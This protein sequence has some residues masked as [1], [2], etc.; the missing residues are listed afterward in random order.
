MSGVYRLNRT[1]NMVGRLNQHK[2]VDGFL[3]QWKTD[4]VGTSN[5]DQ[6]TLPLEIT[7]TY[8]F[9]VAWGD[10]KSDMINGH[11][12]VAVTHTYD[13][14]GTYKIKINGI[15]YGWRFNDG[16]DKLKILNISQWGKKFRLGNSNGYFYGCANLT[17]TATDELDLTNTTTLENAFRNCSSLTTAPSMV[18]W[19]IS[20]ITDMGFMFCGAISFNQDIGDWDVSSVEFMSSMFRATLFNQNIGSW[21]MSSATV[22]TGM[23]YDASVFNQDIGSW[24]VSNV[25]YMNSMFR[26][27]DAFDQDLS[28][29]DVG[30]VTTMG[31][32]F[33]N[34]TLS[35]A[36]YDAL[37]VGWEGQA[38]QD[39]VTFDGGNSKYTSPG[40]AAT[41]RQAL[42]DDHT[43]SISDGGTA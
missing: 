40:A 7:G 25:G 31:S 26:N 19:D 6:I 42:I 39:N 2:K 5:D 20:N 9:T 16:G 17:I 15:C 27:A 10:G 11:D 18:R 35:T 41:A 21:V 24:D 37:L 1:N 38:V 4:N 3:S 14:A 43:W 13:S 36:N 22:L 28:D 34:V 29:W 30:A 23:F 32:M 33:L 8:D 12:D